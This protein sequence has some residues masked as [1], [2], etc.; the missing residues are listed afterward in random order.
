MVSLPL[1]EVGVNCMSMGGVWE[2]VEGRLTIWT[3]EKGLC[4]DRASLGFLSIK[5][6]DGDRDCVNVLLGFVLASCFSVKFTLLEE[7]G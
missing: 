2:G 7:T 5:V 4:S 1:V 3:R 6:G